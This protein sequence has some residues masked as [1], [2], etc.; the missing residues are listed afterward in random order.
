VVEEL[1]LAFVACG[2]TVKVFS[3]KTGLM[4]HQ[5]R[6]AHKNCPVFVHTVADTKTI[7]VLKTG[8]DVHKADIVALNVTQQNNEFILKTLDARG[9]LS[10]WD[11]QEAPY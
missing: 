1:G 9:V 6:E 5:I 10:E 2:S 8:S 4:I 3:I 11:A 7:K